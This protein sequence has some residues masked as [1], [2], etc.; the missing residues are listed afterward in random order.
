MHRLVPFFQHFLRSTENEFDKGVFTGESA[1]VF[2]VFAYLAM[3]ALDNIRG[4]N[5]ASQLFRV[6]EELR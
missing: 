5:N 3:K 6:F 4:I 2:C 1:F